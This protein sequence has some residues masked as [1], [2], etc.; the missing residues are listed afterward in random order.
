VPFKIQKGRVEGVVDGTEIAITP[1]AALDRAFVIAQFGGRELT[2]ISA[3][4]Y[5]AG[6]IAFDGTSKLKV[7]LPPG[8]ATPVGGLLPCAVSYFVVECTH[9]EF[10]TEFHELSIPTSANTATVALSRAYDLGESFIVGNSGLAT[11]EVVSRSHNAFAQFDFSNSSTARVRRHASPTDQVTATAF[12]VV[13]WLGCAVQAVTQSISGAGPYTVTIEDVDPL[14]TVVFSS[15]RH[16]VAQLEACSLAVRLASAT[17]VV[18]ERF[19]DAVVTASTLGLFVV[20]LPDD[21]VEVRHGTVGPVGTGVVT[22]DSLFPYLFDAG[23]TAAYVTA[24]TSGTGTAFPRNRWTVEIPSNGLLRMKRSSTGNDAELAFWAAEFFGIAELQVDPAVVRVRADDIGLEEGVAVTSAPLRL[25][26]DVASIGPNPIDERAVT[27]AHIGVVAGTIQVE[28]AV[29]VGSG[30][31]SLLGPVLPLPGRLGRGITVRGGSQ[32][33]RER[34]LAR[35]LREGSEVPTLVVGGRVYA[36]WKTLTIERSL[37]SVADAFQLEATD[38]APFS[39]SPGQ[40]VELRIGP[41]LVLTGHIDARRASIEE[42]SHS[43]ELA[44]RSLA[45]DVVDCS[46]IHDDA[47][48]FDIGLLELAQRLAAP[49]G[50]PVRERVVLGGLGPRFAVFALQQGESPWE[51]LERA[52][53]MRGVLATSAPDGAIELGRLGQRFAVVALNHGQNVLSATVAEN[54][55]ERFAEYLVR[56]QAPSQGAFAEDLDPVEELLA[57]Y[58]PQGRALDH[59]VRASRRLLVV[60]EAS[61]D[62]ANAARRAQW[63]ASVRA[64][65]SEVL[66]IGV[67]GWR[68]RPGG[69]VWEPGLL[70]PVSV[71]PLRVRGVLVVRAVRMTLDQSNGRRTELELARAGAFAPEPELPADQSLTTDWLGEADAAGFE[72]EESL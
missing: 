53:R 14:R 25:R 40:R 57:A 16:S 20:E 49:Y 36:G 33:R 27:S 6:R 42:E 19:D 61:I 54:Q 31:Q 68:Q 59:S 47:E 24:S 37:D 63:E 71:A 70:V 43:V 44:G 29:V 51:A 45:A 35:E 10:V 56:G 15:C 18:A 62:E 55:A 48:W 4:Q 7:R 58:A 38:V 52:A 17:S 8:A 23:R 50:V 65:R 22:Q 9:E 60:A 39:L 41:D 67:Q 32:E 3:P 64:A 1:V 2:G 13:E 34:A 30:A 12:W 66:S 28:G 21:Q 69:P 72:P 11:D 26:A 5:W 46:A